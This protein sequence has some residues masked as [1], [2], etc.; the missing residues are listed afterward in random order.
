MSS[1]G[2]RDRIRIDPAIHHGEP[3][4]VGTR[5]PVRTI[6]ACL[7]DGDSVDDVLQN[8][9]QLEREDVR[10]ALQYAAEAVET[11]QLIPLTPQCA[12]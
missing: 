1:D 5:I 3:C 12:S 9:P 6:V 11:S 2:S 4:I 7:G 10:E 8:W